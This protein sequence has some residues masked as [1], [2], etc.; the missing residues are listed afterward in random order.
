MYVDKSS[1][2]KHRLASQ[3]GNSLRMDVCDQDA[4]LFR[5][6]RKK[7][8]PGTHAYT[9]PSRS[10]DFNIDGGSG[11]TPCC[12]KTGVFFAASGT[13]H[14]VAILKA[15]VRGGR[16]MI[17]PFQGAGVFFAATGTPLKG[18]WGGDVHMCILL[19]PGD[20]RCL[21]SFDF[22]NIS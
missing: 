12:A 3:K 18:Q 17:Y 20:G 9:T 10:P 14:G 4:S 1:D 21:A 2:R 6:L 22:L 16:D 15:G 8:P 5:W 7:R 13:L 11:D 19:L